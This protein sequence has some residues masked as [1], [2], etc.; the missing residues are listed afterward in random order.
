MPS[1]RVLARDCCSGDSGGVVTPHGPGHCRSCALFSVE[2][3]ELPI[4]AGQRQRPDRWPA[5]GSPCARWAST[6]G[7]FFLGSRVTWTTVGFR[8]LLP[9]FAGSTTLSWPSR[10]WT[11]RRSTSRTA[12]SPGRSG[13]GWLPSTSAAR[14]AT[15]S[16]TDGGLPGPQGHVPGVREV[17]LAATGSVQCC[18]PGEARWIVDEGLGYF[19]QAQSV[20]PAVTTH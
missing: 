11:K 9:A 5:S 8:Q 3:L 13:S 4:R 17:A 18:E 6:E 16:R 14:P 1:I 15:T 2:L 20:Y 12:G 19:G 7:L 10:S